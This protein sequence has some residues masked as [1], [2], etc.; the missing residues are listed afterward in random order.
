[1]AGGNPGLGSPHSAS[2]HAGYDSMFVR[3][4]RRLRCVYLR[5]RF[6]WPSAAAIFSTSFTSDTRTVVL[7]M[8]ANA[9]ASRNERL[10]DMSASN[11]CDALPLAPS[12]NSEIGT[13]RTAAISTRRPVPIRLIPA[14]YFCTCWNVMPSRPPS[15]ACESPLAMRQRRTLRPTAMSIRLGRLAGLLAIAGPARPAGFGYD[16]PEDRK[17]LHYIP[18][19]QKSGRTQTNRLTGGSNGL[20]GPRLGP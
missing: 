3:W 11:E 15:C 10:S 4:R 12:N 19:L 8:A 7:V 2:L 13:C 1:N 6:G 16:D 14:S 18:K 17:G 20:P 5:R 9:R